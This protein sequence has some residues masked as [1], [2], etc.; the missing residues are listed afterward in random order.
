MLSHIS[1]RVAGVIRIAPSIYSR[2][3]SN[4]ANELEVRRKRLRIQS[5]Y[6]GIRENDFLLGTFG[7]KH[8]SS[9]PE[10]LLSQYE[11]LLAQPDW[12]IYNWI[13]KAKPVPPEHDNEIMK[14]LH[15]HCSSNPLKDVRQK[16][17]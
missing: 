13:S 1:S 7:D 11:S 15:A 17:L 9:L 2:T 16:G 3:A 4:S 12:D 6:M 5:K 8:L 14:M 10:Q